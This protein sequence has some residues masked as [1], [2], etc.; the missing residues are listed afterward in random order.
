MLIELCF[1][2][3]VFFST[4][5]L[6]VEIDKGIPKCKQNQLHYLK[7]KDFNNLYNI[8]NTNVTLL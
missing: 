4:K 2:N 3:S 7:L 5:L 1:I 8:I 6:R